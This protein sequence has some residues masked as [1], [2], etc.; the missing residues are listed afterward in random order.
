MCSRVLC[1]K[2][3]IQLVQNSVFCN[4]S[5]YSLRFSLKSSLL[6]SQ[7]LADQCC[8]EPATSSPHFHTHFKTYFNIVLS[9][10]HRFSQWSLYSVKFCMTC[11]FTMHITC[12]F[13]FIID[14]DTPY[15]IW[16]RVKIFKL[17]WRWNFLIPKE[18]LYKEHCFSMFTGCWLDIASS[19][20]QT[21]NVWLFVIRDVWG[22]FHSIGCFN[23]FSFSRVG[24]CLL[25]LHYSSEALFHAARLIYFLDKA[26][27]GSKGTVF[28]I[29][30]VAVY[31]LSMPFWNCKSINVMNWL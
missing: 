3:D 23:V 9:Y 5:V 15:V 29:L 20:Y 7:Q 8:P 31:E 4:Q 25:A 2:L 14:F 10:V 24:I 16:Y 11:S 27:N 28:I 30:K 22:I 26:E 21:T 12:P 18:H 17:L 6:C 13:H 1:D 19:L